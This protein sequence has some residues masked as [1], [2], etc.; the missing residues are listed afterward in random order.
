[1]SFSRNFCISLA[2]VVLGNLIYFLIMPHLPP[3]AQHRSLHILPDLG[4]LVDFWI[5]LV[6]YGL[7][8][9]LFRPHEGQRPPT[10]QRR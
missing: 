9:F 7:I 1:M 4:L 2:A 10:E 3:A 8:A 6:L 5:C